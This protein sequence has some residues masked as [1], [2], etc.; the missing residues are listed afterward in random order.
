MDE[1]LATKLTETDVKGEE[2]KINDYTMVVKLKQV[3]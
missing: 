3:K 2:L 1:V